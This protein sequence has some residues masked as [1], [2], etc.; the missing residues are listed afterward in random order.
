MS[1]HED[2]EE[3]MRDEW[4]NQQIEEELR[5]L[6]ETPVFEYLAHYG[7]AIEAR[8]RACLSEA[9]ALLD[10]G[11]AGAAVV[12]A[13]A[14]IEITVRFFLARP[15][16]QSAFLSNDWAQLLSQKFLNGRTAEDRELLPAILRNWKIDITTFKLPGGHQL[17]E[18][19]ITHVWPSRN[20]YV[21]TGKMLGVEAAELAIDS[22]NA[23]LNDLV[24]TVAN[25]LGFTRSRTGTWSTIA[26][27]NPIGFPDLN[28][29]VEYE[30][31]DPF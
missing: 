2:D 13:A 6:A 8:V 12:R 5:Q 4:L 19:V 22:L 24:A 18:T 29:P 27:D 1:L 25:R 10:A 23:F 21:H 9:R 3:M 14:G 26:R 30:K 16:L 31:R 15:L 7:D 11:F 28:P 17:W 20:E